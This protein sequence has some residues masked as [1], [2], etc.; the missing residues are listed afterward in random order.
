MA[1]PVYLDYNATAP[2]RP[3]VIE[4][5]AETLGRVGNAS[6]L[7]G[8]G[9]DA[10]AA[11][12]RARA[13]VAGLVGAAPEEVF[14]TASGTE[15]DNW[16][17]AGFGRS[18][19]L[20]SA[21]EH[22]AVL[23]AA[24]EAG[25]IPL[26]G[27]G[28]VDLEA[29]ERLLDASDEPALVSVQAANN[30]TGA[31]QPLAEV[32]E[33]ARRRGALLH[34]DAVQAAGKL[35]L[36]RAA[37]GL[38][39]VSLSAHKLGGPQGVGALVVRGG[40]EPA[41]LLRGGGQERRRRAGTENVAGIVGFGLAA[42]LAAAELAETAHRAAWRDGF[43]AALAERL[44]EAVVFAAG[45]PRL[46]NTSCF[47]LPGRRA[48]TLLIGLDLAGVAL[49]SGSAC[50]SGKVVPSHVLAAMGVPAGLVAGALRLSF[51]W[52]SRRRDLDRCLE[53]LVA[54]AGPRENDRQKERALA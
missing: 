39:L 8:F 49:S 22:P 53:A 20:V 40:L 48:E 25:I 15:A 54:R 6:S 41:P 52:A 45:A 26:T 35:P 18:R 14:F 43:E 17:L 37:L 27:G 42:E 29:L 36:D 28:L 31:V 38:D 32:A 24:P 47:A 12:E 1:E 4:A 34:S 19:R 10:R 46:P 50:S 9:R 5:V 11:V 3:A 2:V 7:H 51:G 16:A 13:Q 44:P 33:L 23:A 30:E 21:G